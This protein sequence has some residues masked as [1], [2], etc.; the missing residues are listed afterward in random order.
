VNWLEL[1]SSW[2]LGCCFESGNETIP[3]AF[4]KAAGCKP[5]GRVMREWEW[6]AGRSCTVYS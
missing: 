1:A 6:N 4:G 5:A 2:R 3:P